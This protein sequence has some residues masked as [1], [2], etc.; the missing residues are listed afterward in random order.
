MRYSKNGRNTIIEQPTIEAVAFR[1]GRIV[2]TYEDGRRLSLPLEW[3]PMLHRATDAQRMDYVLIGGGTGV[4]WDSIGEALSAE[5]F[6]K[7]LAQPPM[8]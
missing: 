8:P 1:R 4:L 3:Y 5:G 6:L 2:V 7:G